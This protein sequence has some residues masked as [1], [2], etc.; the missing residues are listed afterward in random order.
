MKGEDPIEKLKEQVAE[1]ELNPDDLM[2]DTDADPG[3]IPRVRHRRPAEIPS[4]RERFEHNITHIPY[5]PW[6]EVCVAARGRS[7]PHKVIK[8]SH[9]MAPV[10]AFDFAF[11]P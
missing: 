5:R 3:D 10:I 8:V 9:T 11:F 6:C 7:D 4:E 1:P 2:P